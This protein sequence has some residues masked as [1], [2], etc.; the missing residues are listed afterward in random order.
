MDRLNQSY[1]LPRLHDSSQ[2]YPQQRISEHVLESLEK[3]DVKVKVI[4]IPGMMYLY[5]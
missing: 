2:G 3:N 1:S 5:T 4:Y